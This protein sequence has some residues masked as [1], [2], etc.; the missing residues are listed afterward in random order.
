MRF[1]CCASTSEQIDILAQAGFD[2][3]ELQAAAVQPFEDD[4]AAL[5]ALHIL[6]S[7]RLRPEAF[8]V[9]V[10]PQLP[11]SGP[12]ADHAALRAYLR[13]TFGRMVRLG[14]QV[15]VLGSGGARR[16]PDSVTREQGLAQLAVSLAIAADEAANAGII[17]ALEHLNRKETNV[18][19][20]VAESQEFITQIHPHLAQH[21]MKLLADLFH[22]EV[23]H[24]PL[25]HV[26]VAGPLLAHVHVA[27]GERRAPDVAGYDYSGFMRVLHAVGY[28]QR[29]SA[30]C[31]WEDLGQQAAGAL[32]FM[33]RSWSAPG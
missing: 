28:D 17:L 15:V 18:F 16:I 2:Y 9:L 12:H 4:A 5:P 1:G 19:N 23:E 29:I 6:E 33:R 25:Q 7:A 24:E 3:C 21:G 11:L 8:N 27:G 26:A 31:S 10:P 32:D 22:L 14:G 13:R 20:S 30:E